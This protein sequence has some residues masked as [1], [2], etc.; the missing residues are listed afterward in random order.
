MGSMNF[1]FGVVFQLVLLAGFGFFLQHKKFLDE[2]RAQF[3]TDVLINVCIPALIISELSRNFSFALRPHWFLIIAWSFLICIVGGALGF[4]FV[5]LFSKRFPPRET[6]SLLAFQNCGYLPMVLA[7]FMFPESLRDMF[8]VYIFIYLI[9]FN[10]IFWSVSPHFF[11][12]N[13]KT[14]LEFKDFFNLPTQATVISLLFVLVGLN[15]FIPATVLDCFSAIGSVSFVLSMI[16]LGYELSRSALRG[17]TFDR[18][19]GLCI[20]SFGK[21]VVVPLV[22]FF[23]LLVLRIQD[24]FGLFLIIQ[25][26]VP[27]AVSLTVIARWKNLDAEFIAQNLLFSHLGSILTLPVWI[28]IFYLSA[29]L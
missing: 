17:I 5:Y 23:V 12:K 3:L 9:G 14:K 2:T 6:V 29:G 25:A 4:L 28:K 26:A 27:S 15:R 8:L 24:I 13:S 21:L 19:I 7:H 10:F 16:L 11:F 20:V 22:F 18:F 1:L